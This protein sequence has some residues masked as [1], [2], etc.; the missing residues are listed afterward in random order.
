MLK[1]MLVMALA[2]GLI[3]GLTTV[4]NAGVK[5]GGSLRTEVVWGYATDEFPGGDEK[6]KIITF[7]GNYSRLKFTYLSDDKKFKGYAEIGIYS[8][9]LNGNGV[10]TRH[11][12]FTYSWG[13]GELLFGQTLSI[14][15]INGPASWQNGWGLSGGYGWHSW[16]RNEQIRLT[17]GE[18]YRLRFALEAPIKTLAYDDGGTTVNGYHY[19]P[20]FGASLKLN[21]GNVAIMPW[22]HWEWVR[23]DLSVGDKNVHCLDLGIEISGDFGLVG[24]IF[25]ASYGF[26]TASAGDTV[27]G[28]P[29]DT[30]PIYSATDTSNHKEFAFYGNLKVGGLSFG[31]GYQSATRDPLDGVELWNQRDWR[32]GAFIN[33]KIPFGKVKFIPE[34][35]WRHGGESHEGVDRGDQVRVGVYMVLDF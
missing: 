9:H 1:K 5:I 23:Y 19:L 10:A 28:N 2:L 3:V 8:R 21:F 20:G 29:A 32:M 30:Y 22:A 14:E 35:T 34:M 12:Y 13:K 26:N 6:F 7:N 31:A 27:S 4:A 15:Q 17:M 11:A 33:Y 18:K 16:S 24:F 25:G